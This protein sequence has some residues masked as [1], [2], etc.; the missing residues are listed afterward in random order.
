M[1]QSIVIRYRGLSLRVDRRLPLLLLGLGLLLFA[2]LVLNLGIGEFPIPALDVAK[3]VLRLSREHDFIVLTLRLPRALVALLVGTAIALSG[4]ILQGLT[5]NPLA[6]PDVVGI[7]GGA[8]LAAVVVILFWPNAPTLALPLAAF[9]GAGVAA[10]ITYLFAW[11]GGSS[12]I[13]LIL[14]GMGVA[15]LSQALVTIATV[16]A[17]VLRVNQAM[18]WMTG[19]V[20]NRSWEH[21]KPLAPWLLLFIPLALSLARHLN[22]LHLGDEVARGLGS[23]V[24][25]HRGLLL[26]TSVALAA[27]AIAAAGPVG[28]VGLMAPH[29]ARRLAGPRHGS[30]LPTAALLGGAL[31]LAADLVGRTAFA[32]IEIPCGVVTAAVGAPYFLYLLYRT[33]SR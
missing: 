2:L 7:T 31:V 13:R 5:R 30:L 25:R 23:A 28:F 20:Y 4:A 9:G 21:L 26:L 12:P 22:T 19:S 17:N 27:A 18:V 32:P 11:L 16:Q 1:N 8:N 15:A 3:T 29:M 6:S 10:L 24:E 14:V 33:Q